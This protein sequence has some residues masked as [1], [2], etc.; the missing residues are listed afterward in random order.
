MELDKVQVRVLKPLVGDE[1]RKEN[2]LRQRRDDLERQLAAK[3]AE[4]AKPDSVTPRMHLQEEYAELE[5]QRDQIQEELKERYRARTVTIDLQTA[6]FGGRIRQMEAMAQVEEWLQ[7]RKRKNLGV[8]EG[9]TEQPSRE[10]LQQATLTDQQREDYVV[11]STCTALVGAVCRDDEG[12]PVCSN[13]EWPADMHGWTE[14]PAYIV[15]PALMQAYA[16]NPSWAPDW[17]TVPEDESEK[18]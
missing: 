10:A 12:R 6:S 11:M 17:L 9:A 3:K 18:N 15:E 14:V 13:F 2:E 4:L 7:E 1:L 16:L 8:P 5:A